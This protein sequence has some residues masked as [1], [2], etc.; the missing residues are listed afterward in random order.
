MSGKEAM[1]RVT[2][3]G[4]HD[5]LSEVIINCLREMPNP[6]AD[7]IASGREREIKQGRSAPIADKVDFS[8][9]LKPDTEVIVYLAL[10]RSRDG[11]TPDIGD[12]ESLLRHCIHSNIKRFVLVSSA[13]LYGADP[14][15]TGMLSETSPTVRSSSAAVSGAWGALEAIVSEQLKERPDIELT[16]L[17]HAS[18]PARDGLDYF[19]RL[20]Q[21]PVAVAL[22]GHDPT[23]QLLSAD[24]FA[25]A[26]RCAVERGKNG[27]YNVAP[28]GVITLRAALRLTKTKRLPI[29]RL[30]QRAARALL[31]PTG[32]ALPIEQLDY[33][34]YSW[35]ISGRKIQDELGFIPRH[36]SGE[37]LM[38][39]AESD[40]VCSSGAKNIEREFDEFGMDED[41]IAAYSKTMFKFL[42]RYYW[43]VEVDGIQ[44][45]PREGRAVLTGMHRGFMPWDAVIT[46]NL[47]GRHTGRYPRFLIHPGLIK[48]PF[49]FNFHTK[50]G[51]V[52]ACQ[53]NADY[54]LE[55]DN[56]LGIY[57]EGIRGAFS[58]YRNAYRLGK[59]GRDEFVKTALRNRAPIIPF[60]NVGS[61]EI[62]PIIAK[63]DWRWWKRHTEWP[64]F[65]ITPTWPLVPFPLPS[66]WHVQFL[67]PVHVE[68]RYPP[69][70]A[71][72]AKIVRAI[73]QE[74]REMM[75]AAIN[76]ML[77]RRRSVFWGSVFENKSK[78][79]TDKDTAQNFGIDT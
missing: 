7:L 4:A 1:M 38:K 30:V 63:I 9:F 57:P 17:R 11:M 32:L 68:E 47:I 18:V 74:V 15:N 3:I 8:A 19:S 72:D 61:A 77:S 48:F 5:Y 49:L 26:V 34:R 14:H 39:L 55:R 59:F 2:V 36:S 54:L 45:V 22:P 46:L 29:S 35:T 66:K 50:L 53:E 12:A 71:D 52:I 62:F 20:F 41:Y 42:E 27:I 13:A 73:S 28:R 58:L 79:M 51:G 16:V 44:H 6:G 10:A 67:P 75:A 69:E 21:R 33:I 37:A 65:P 60:V 64:F 43:R 70:A 24:D 78:P 23:I 31:S 56:L 40:P 76:E 25:R